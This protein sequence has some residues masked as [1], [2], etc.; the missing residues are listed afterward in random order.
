[1]KRKALLILAAAILAVAMIP[2]IG[3]G[4]ATGDVKIV[5]PDELANPT[6]KTGSAFDKLEET[7]FVSDK[8]GE[9]R[10]TLEDAGGTL[11]VVI[12][13]NDATANT[14]VPFHAY[15]EAIPAT[16]V[17]GGNLFYLNP[18]I[19][20][21]NQAVNSQ[22]P[23]LVTDSG[24]NFVGNA[25][26]EDEELAA[27]AALV[28]GDANRNEGLDAADIIIETGWYTAAAAAIPATDQ[29]A[30]V[31]AVEA[32]FRSERVVR[33]ANA[34]N[35]VNTDK[36]GVYLD[37]DEIPP[38]NN[39][40]PTDFADA[41]AVVR[42]TFES[43]GV[44]VLEFGDN[45][46][47]N[48]GKSLIEVTS[49]SGD[50]IR[51]P[52]SEADL[53]EYAGLDKAGVGPADFGTEAVESKDSGVFVARFGVIDNDSKDA[54]AEYW[55]LV[56][57]DKIAPTRTL[58]VI[59]QAAEDLEN[60]GDQNDDPPVPAPDDNTVVQGA[61]TSITLKS[62][63]SDN[64]LVAGSLKVLLNNGNDSSNVPRTNT[65]SI[66]YN[67]DGTATIT[68]VNA[69]G[70]P[71]ASEADED[72]EGDETADTFTVNYT[73]ES[74]S[75]TIDAMLASVDAT[76]TDDQGEEDIDEVFDGFCDSQIEGDRDKQCAEAD[77]LRDAVIAHS[78]N[79]GIRTSSRIPAFLNAVIGVQHGDTLAV[80]YSDQSPRSVRSDSAEV[81]LNGPVIG[82]FTL[83]NGAYIDE[84]DFEVLFDVTDADSGILED[85]HDIAEAAIR[86][87]LAYV[88]QVMDV[89]I[90]EAQSGDILDTAELDVDDE[91]DNGERYELTVDVTASAEIAEG[92][93]D[94][95]PVTVR[96]KVTITAYDAARNG[97]DE[98][99]HLHR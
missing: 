49:S 58:T 66:I 8:T 7:N 2:A 47:S 78:E 35:D 90:G 81:D 32:V 17:R 93:D 76:G 38:L 56:P 50:P 12:E 45:A 16:Q 30:A 69:L 42:I 39:V 92:D 29:V 22:V 34:F 95:E 3:V 91:L 26:S 33:A 98:E 31:P 89:T 13:D 43:A 65:A 18:G 73:T 41:T 14:L 99:C 55:D 54:I 21:D 11:Y 40:V 19:T 53:G 37:V 79:L 96:V 77:D 15:Y 28:V 74:A 20:Q 24:E 4:A 64:T 25:A 86:S 63:D 23:T 61:T 83:G 87:G 82:G 1:M 68:V 59:T 36:T 5:T 51:I 88:S 94:T 57:K 9:D 67:G 27:L 6:G 71:S 72:A 60:N 85:S 80:R 84:D 70:Q 62:V 10:A 44:D 75:G 97:I 46:G 48:S 52:A